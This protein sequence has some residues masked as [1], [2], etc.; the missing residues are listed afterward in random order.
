MRHQPIPGG[1][2]GVTRLPGQSL[3]QPSQYFFAGCVAHDENA[4]ETLPGNC[5]RLQ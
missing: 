1:Q 4:G 2:S 3:R 5:N